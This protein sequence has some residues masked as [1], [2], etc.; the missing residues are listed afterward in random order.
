MFTGF[1]NIST[2]TM[3]FRVQCS[4]G[5]CGPDCRT[6]PTNNPLVAEC[7]AD[8]SVTCVDSKRDPSLPVPCSDCLYNLDSSTNCSTCLQSNYDP[9]NNCMTCLPNYDIA[10]NCSMCTNRRYDQ[11]NNCQSCLDSNFNPLDE[12]TSCLLDLYDPRT[13]CTQ[14]LPNRNTSTNCTQCL[15][16][17]DVTSNCTKCLLPNRNP[18]SNCT[19]CLGNRNPGFTGNNC[20]RGE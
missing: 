2:M 12:C 10:T 6:I 9:D 17:W 16:D 15:P 8:G 19:Q 14:C 5:F 3:S 20:E 13:N 1:H 18:D 4:S 11:A 7:Q